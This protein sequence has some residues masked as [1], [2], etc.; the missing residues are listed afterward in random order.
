MSLFTKKY[1]QD[2]LLLLLNITVVL[3]AVFG[4]LVVLFRID[5]SQSVAIIQYQSQ[6]GLAG[7]ERASSIQLY[8]FAAASILFAAAAIFL[9]P[10]LFHIK[11]YLSVACL[12]LT[13]LTLI[14]NIIVS[15][16]VLSLQ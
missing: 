11:R 5:T 2:R 13:I 8:S 16:S 7:F 14:L 6:L 4:V 1:F 15:F 9:S 3:L 10:R 12:S